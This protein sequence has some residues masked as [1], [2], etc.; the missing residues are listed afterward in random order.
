M[1]DRAKEALESAKSGHAPTD[2]TSS[3]RRAEDVLVQENGRDLLK[4]LMGSTRTMQDKNAL[5]TASASSQSSPGNASQDPLPARNPV[6]GNTSSPPTAFESFA[7]R[8]TKGSMFYGV[9]P[10]A[11]TDPLSALTGAVGVMPESS[12]AMPSRMGENRI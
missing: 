9:G 2:T 10:Y 5:G 6:A 3:K 11:V 4:V 1:Y 7:D 8:S 12:V